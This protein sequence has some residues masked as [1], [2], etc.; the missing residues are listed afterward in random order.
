MFPD[1]QAVQRMSKEIVEMINESVQRLISTS[2]G[3]EVV[4]IKKRKAK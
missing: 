3:A 1:M 4:D 2:T